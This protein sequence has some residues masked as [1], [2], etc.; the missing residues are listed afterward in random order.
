[1][2]GNITN[3]HVADWL[4]RIENKVKNTKKENNND[5][6]KIAGSF[7]LQLNCLLNG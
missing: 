5:S 7:L 2:G 4:G 3:F 1:M 6:N